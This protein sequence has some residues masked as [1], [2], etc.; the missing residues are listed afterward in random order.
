MWTDIAWA[1]HPR[2]IGSFARARDLPAPSLQTGRQWGLNTC[3]VKTS[4]TFE[5]TKQSLPH[6]FLAFPLWS[7]QSGSEQWGHPRPWRMRYAQSLYLICGIW[8][9]RWLKTEHL[10]FFWVLN[11]L[12][13]FVWSVKNGVFWITCF[14][15]CG[16][17]C[18]FHAHQRFA[19]SRQPRV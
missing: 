16:C 11:L 14:S 19:Q 18:D 7:W 6:R 9:K 4:E 2:E 17:H 12:F 5:C 1:E 3:A 15:S 13:L 8:C 10:T